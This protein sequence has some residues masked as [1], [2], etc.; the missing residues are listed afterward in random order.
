MIK[1]QTPER[2][3]LGFAKEQFK[4]NG[5]QKEGINEKNLYIHNRIDGAG[6]LH[7]LSGEYA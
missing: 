7:N 6:R 3:S 2:D 1:I 4:K 5:K